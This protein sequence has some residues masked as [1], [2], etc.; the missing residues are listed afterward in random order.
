MTGQP[1]PRSV[2]AVHV[3]AAALFCF[4]QGCVGL[5]ETALVYANVTLILHRRRGLSIR[6]FRSTLFGSIT[7]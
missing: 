1:T 4:P 7:I 3:W 2:A 5:R 6:R